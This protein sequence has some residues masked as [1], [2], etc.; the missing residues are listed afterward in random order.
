MFLCQDLYFKIC[1]HHYSQLFFELKQVLQKYHFF[2][3]LLFACFVKVKLVTIIK[4]K[5]KL[6]PLVVEVVVIIV[7][8][9][10]VV[11]IIAIVFM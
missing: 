7:V 2:K 4:L 10:V 5:L 8:E 6:Q 1:Y 11:I 9:L 3:L